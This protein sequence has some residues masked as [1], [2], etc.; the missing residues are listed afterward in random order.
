M[1]T[2]QECQ[3][4]RCEGKI[5][6]EWVE[7]P[8]LRP[9]SQHPTCPLTWKLLRDQSFKVSTE[10]HHTGMVG[11]ITGHLC[12]RYPFSPPWRTWVALKVPPL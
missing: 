7:L 12:I 3:V 6:G 2:A 10:A 9:P 5:T 1:G 11:E 4:K 8:A